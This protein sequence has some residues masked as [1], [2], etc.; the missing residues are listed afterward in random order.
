[1]PTLSLVATITWAGA[2]VSGATVTLSGGPLSLSPMSA[3]TSGSG[4]V[5]FTNV[6][7]GSGYTLTASKNGARPRR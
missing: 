1:M 5:T 3:T 2:N 6:P 7:A 4:Q